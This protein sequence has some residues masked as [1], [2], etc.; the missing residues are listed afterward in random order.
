MR[1][2]HL[3]TVNEFGF[4]TARV[5]SPYLAL[6]IGTSAHCYDLR[7]AVIVWLR[8]LSIARV[9]ARCRN[10]RVG[11]ARFWRTTRLG[12]VCCNLKF[13]EPCFS[14]LFSY[15]SVRY[16]FALARFSR[17]SSRFRGLARSEPSLPVHFG[18]G[19]RR[20]DSWSTTARRGEIVW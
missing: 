12:R 18:V 3:R 7:G 2:D 16:C 5:T 15:R 13:V 14:F 1:R 4:N 6:F 11:S 19:R 8:S 10:V 20:G 17:S 9:Y